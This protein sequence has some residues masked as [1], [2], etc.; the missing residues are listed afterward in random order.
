MEINNQTSERF[1]IFPRG[2]WDEK[3]QKAKPQQ[4]QQQTQTVEWVYEYITSTRAKRATEELR[5]ME[6]AGAS[7]EQLRDYKLLNFEYATFSGVFR[8]RRAA[9]IVSRTPFLTIDIDDLSSYDEA[10]RLQQQ[11]VGDPE[12]QTVLCFVSPKGRGVKW[13]VRLP[14]WTDGLVFRRQYDMVRSYVGFTYGVDADKSGSDICRA[15]F[16]PW[17]PECYIGKP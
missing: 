4:R 14:R 6:A 15:C 11:L 1:S 13:V 17:D 16:L 2:W 5:H 3:D 9:F 10:R 12:L 8:Y 7:D